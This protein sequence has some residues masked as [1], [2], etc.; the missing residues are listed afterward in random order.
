MYPDLES[1]L[2]AGFKRS[3]RFDCVYTVQD[4]AK[5]HIIKNGRIITQENISKGEKENGYKQESKQERDSK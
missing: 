4:G 5:T 1:A 3:R 2:Y